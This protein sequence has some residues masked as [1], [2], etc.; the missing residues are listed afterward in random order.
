VVG[1]PPE[2]W[3]SNEFRVDVSQQALQISQRSGLATPLVNPSPL[4][5]QERVVVS[6]TFLV[7]GTMFYCLTVVPD[8]EATTFAETLQ[9]ITASI[10]LTETR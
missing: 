6:T 10:R 2:S 8:K 9:R 1:Q 7:D 3:Q 4:G 5:G